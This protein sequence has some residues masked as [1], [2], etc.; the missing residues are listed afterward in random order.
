LRDRYECDVRTHDLADESALRREI[1]SSDI[2]L[3]GTPVGM[4][5]LRGRSIIPDATYFHEGLIVSDVIIVPAETTL[6]ELARRA[7]CR[8]VTGTAM[9]IFQ[10]ASAFKVW[11]NKEMAI[12]VVKSIASRQ[13]PDS[14][15]RHGQ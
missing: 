7:G 9:N 11:T 2:F 4:D 3:N 15:S 8:T 5:P 13:N 10:A 12:D 6:L 14:P 1:A